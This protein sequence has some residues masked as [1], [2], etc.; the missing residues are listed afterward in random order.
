[1]KILIADD[2]ERLAERI[3]HKLRDAFIVDKALSGE[4]ALK[5][6]NNVSYGSIILD[7]NL[8]GISGLEVCRK[9]RQNNCDAPILVLTGQNDIL[10]KVELLEAGADDYMT[11]PFD[12]KELR[13]R[14]GALERRS[15]REKPTE[16]LHFNDIL[17]DLSRRE[18]SRTGVSIQLRR[19]EFDILAYLIKNKGR[20]MTRQMIM[21]HVW[22]QDSTSWTSTV[23]VHIKHL[24]DKIDKPFNVHYIKT[25]YGLGYKVDAAQ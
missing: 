7:L 5:Q 22:A 3:A 25:A 18:V 10:S 14:L 8:P 4:D 19:K 12:I 17:I 15:E 1:M 6:V 23:D 2:N 9:I 11:K 21:D 24:R 20:I 13:A 16:F